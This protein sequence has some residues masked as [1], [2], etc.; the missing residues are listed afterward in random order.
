M[1]LIKEVSR[2]CPSAII[3]WLGLRFTEISFWLGLLKITRF[4]L[5]FFMFSNNKSLNNWE[6][7]EWLQ[8]FDL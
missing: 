5:K 2:S 7:Y 6:I 1:F 8:R 4:E 3:D